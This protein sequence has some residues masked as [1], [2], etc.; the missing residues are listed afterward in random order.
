MGVV[1][2]SV[3]SGDFS[4]LLVGGSS[5]AFSFYLNFSY[6]EF[7]RNSYLLWPLRAAFMWELPDVD[8]VVSP[9]FLVP[10]PFC[11]RCLHVFHQN[12]LAIIPLTGDVFGV[13]VMRAYIGC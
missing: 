2:F 9:I 12:V 10:V 4:F 6:S 7:R 13:A 8:C 3:L 5:S 11:C 1:C